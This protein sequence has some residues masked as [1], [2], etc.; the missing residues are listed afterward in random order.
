[1]IAAT[2]ATAVLLPGSVLVE[3]GSRRDG[4]VVSHEY[5]RTTGAPRKPRKFVPRD[6]SSTSTIWLGST[7][8]GGALAAI[9]RLSQE[10]VVRTDRAG[11]IVWSSKDWK[12]LQQTLRYGGVAL[13]SI[14]GDDGATAPKMTDEHHELIAFDA[15]HGT[16]RWHR[17]LG[18]H[19]TLNTVVGG[20]VVVLDLDDAKKLA[21][22]DARTGAPRWE[23]PL[24]GTAAVVWSSGDGIVA[25]T[26]SSLDIVKLDPATGRVVWQLTPPETFVKDGRLMLRSTSPSPVPWALGE[27]FAVVVDAQVAYLIDYASG[28]LAAVKL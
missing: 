3:T 10:A 12:P 5:D 4:T 13:A 18:R 2:G 8:D 15:A 26:G 7:E 17:P 14:Q 19:A 22:L 20:C 24:T 6:T 27:Q 16:V 25:A 28:K 23:R 11:L 21:C 9:G 1:M